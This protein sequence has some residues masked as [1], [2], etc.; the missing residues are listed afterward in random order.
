MR[1]T[2]LLL[3]AS[4]SASAAHAAPPAWVNHGSELKD[5]TALGVGIGQSME[6]ALVLSLAEV[7]KLTQKR[8][9]TK[10]AFGPFEIRWKS[11]DSVKDAGGG[12]EEIVAALEVE[13]RFRKGA[14]TYAAV[15]KMGSRSASD[16]SSSKETLDLRVQSDGIAIGE[17]ITEL[18]AQGFTFQ[19]WRDPADYT[20]FVALTRKG[21]K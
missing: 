20:H 12:K 14:K 9:D 21:T 10:R 2:A 18:G 19:D 5:G 6:M 17:L 1:L 11:A 4:L 15:V 8:G 3:A 7:A 16:M 13:L